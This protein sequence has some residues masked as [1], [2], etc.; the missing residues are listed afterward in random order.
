MFHIDKILR[1]EKKRAMG[2][3]GKNTYLQKATGSRNM[4]PVWI[5]AAGRPANFLALTATRGVRLD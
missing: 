5:A 4:G 3:K 2:K 1:N